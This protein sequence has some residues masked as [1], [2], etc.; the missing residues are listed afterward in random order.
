M[1]NEQKIQQLERQVQELLAWKEQK[2]R[3]QISYPLDQQSK[4]IANRDN[5]VL[6]GAI[7]API[8]LV[9][10]SHYLP[11]EINGRQFFL[12]ATPTNI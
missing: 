1:N 3:Q 5:L 11:G 8:G 10:S 2:T 9:P 7:I 6:T 4:E 12:I